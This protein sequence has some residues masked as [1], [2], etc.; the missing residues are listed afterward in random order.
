MDFF[1]YKR[2]LIRIHQK[3][4]VSTLKEMFIFLGNEILTTSF[5]FQQK[6]FDSLQKILPLRHITLMFS[7][8]H[9]NYSKQNDFLKPSNQNEMFIFQGSEI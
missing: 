4:R 1:W 7:E 2:F 6:R 8:Y 3:F 9:F 5:H